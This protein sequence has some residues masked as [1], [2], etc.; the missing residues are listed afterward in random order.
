MTMDSFCSPASKTIDSVSPGV[1]PS[2]CAT[3]DSTWRASDFTPPLAVASDGVAC[4]DV[5]P[6]WIYSIDQT[7]VENKRIKIQ[8][9]SATNQIWTLG[10]PGGSNVAHD[11]V[12]TASLPNHATEVTFVV[13]IIYTSC[14]TTPLNVPTPIDREY[15]VT[16]P[17]FNYDVPA[18]SIYPTCPTA[19]T[20]T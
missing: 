19:I 9:D 12:V 7:G 6:Q 20:Y 8:V 10:I 17:V 16:D 13:K 11:L 3:Y 2:V 4:T 18:F 5:A 1:A 15:I 14:I